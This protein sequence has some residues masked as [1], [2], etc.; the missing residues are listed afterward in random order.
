MANEPVPLFCQFATNKPASEA[1]QKMELTSQHSRIEEETSNESKV[2]NQP[3]PKSFPTLL[4]KS[5]PDRLNSMKPQEDEELSN[6][7][8][9]SVVASESRNV[10]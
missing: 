5:G 3:P 6:E 4:A 7:L 9:R 8:I 10:C 1:A 2:E